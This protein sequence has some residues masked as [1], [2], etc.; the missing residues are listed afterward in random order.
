MSLHADRAGRLYINS[1]ADGSIWVDSLEA[2]SIVYGVWGVA[3]CLCLSAPSV[4]VAVVAPVPL[5]AR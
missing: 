4:V 1:E 3:W 2:H 5:D